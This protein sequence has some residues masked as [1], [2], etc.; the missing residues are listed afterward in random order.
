VHGASQV[1]DIEFPWQGI[2]LHDYIICELH[3]GIF[4]SE[5]TS[6]AA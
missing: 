3:V 1:I 2:P 4:T 6:E 5:G